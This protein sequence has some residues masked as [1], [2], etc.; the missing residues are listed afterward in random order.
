LWPL[1][2]FWRLTLQTDFMRTLLYLWRSVSLFLVVQFRWVCLQWHQENISQETHFKLN[3]SFEVWKD[4]FRGFSD[5]FGPCQGERGSS[6]GMF[7]SRQ[8][9]YELPEFKPT[10]SW[11][12]FDTRSPR[13]ALVPI[14]SNHSDRFAP[15]CSINKFLFRVILGSLHV[16]VPIGTS[17]KQ[18]E[19]TEKYLQHCFG[20]YGINH[21]TI[22]PEIHQDTPS[23][24]DSNGEMTGK[25]R[26]P[27][28]G[29][30]GCAV[31][32]LQ[33]RKVVTATA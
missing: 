32:T 15:E 22:S 8:I 29:D 6:L 12:A 26:L 20:E 21:V 14:V 3:R 27:S 7:L 25:C 30:L 2:Y 13:L 19:R 18:W 16:C 9:Q 4:S 17:L 1:L 28:E 11:C 10:D 24:T 5:T 23:I 31:N 33:K